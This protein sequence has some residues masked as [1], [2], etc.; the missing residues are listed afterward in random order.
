M[1]GGDLGC[2]ALSCRAQ[3]WS[4]S[5]WSLPAPTHAPALAIAPPH[6]CSA[7][8]PPPISSSLR[9]LQRPGGRKE[10]RGQ[11]F[12]LPTSTPTRIPTYLCQSWS[13]T[14]AARSQH[15]SGLLP[16][17]LSRK[18]LRDFPGGAVC[19]NPPASAGD[20]SLNPGLGRFYALQ[21]N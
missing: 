20:S 14:G 8:V 16:A 19:K 1:A 3:P 11:G 13:G 15:H 7:P 21:S 17:R 18:A 5:S 9:G 10:R 6:P 2:E 12:L 4:W